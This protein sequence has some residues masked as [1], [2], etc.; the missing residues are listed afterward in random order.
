MKFSYVEVAGFRGFRDVTRFSFPAGFVVLTGR[1]GAGKS[2]VLD[3]IDYAFTGSINKY[4]IKGAKG[5]GLDSHIWWVGDGAPRAQYVEV[6]LVA[7]N[8][9]TFKIMRSRDRGLQTSMEEIGT[10][11]CSDRMAQCSWQETF[12]QT[13][14]IRDETLSGLS[15]DLP[16]QARFEAVRA[17]IGGLTG[18]DHSARTTELSK[19]A[20]AAKKAQDARLAEVQADLG[21]A[22]S[23]LT[24]ARSIAERQPDVSEAEEIIHRMAPDLTFI[25]GDRPEALR[26]RV[27]ERKQSIPDLMDAIVR[28]EAALADELFFTS[29]EGLACALDLAAQAEA[30][31]Q[32]KRSALAALGE[33][34]RAAA[35]EQEAD[36]F[37]AHMV[38]LLQ[39]GEGVGL[40]EGH[41]PLCNAV[42]SDGDFYNALEAARA[43]LQARG[44]AAA[45]AADSLTK[46]RSLALQAEQELAAAKRT[47][48]EFDSRRSRSAQALAAARAVFARHSVPADPLNP[49]RSR[50]LA[51]KRQEETAQLEHALFILEASGAHDRV[52]ALETRVAQLRGDVEEESLRATAAGRAVE[53]AKQID[54]AAKAVGNQILT[55][56]FDTVMPLL[57]ELYQRLRPHT[58][59]REIETDFG[60]EVRAS[61]NFTVGNGRNPQF[62]FSSGQ[63]RAAGLAF[64]LAIHLSRPWCRLRSLLLD[65]PVQHIDDYRALNLVEVLSAIR[66]MGRQVIIA[67]E[68]PA[69]ADLLCRRLRST[70]E[71]TGRRFDLS[72]GPSGSAIIDSCVDVRPLPREVLRFAE[73]S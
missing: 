45:R 62:L 3:A 34:E 16:E 64:L 9:Q 44:E 8:G 22:L 47:L 71:E 66:R 7:P 11:L 32:R 36:A 29:D 24:E 68:D 21:R 51:L 46:S 30:L 48:E 14:L 67:V 17:A 31:E 28:T 23:A 15:L 50:A 25:S 59:W 58:D 70:P 69:L 1:N 49:E 27:A 53:G 13:T 60:G 26:R 37:A 41:C 18:P 19:A 54:N 52:T 61:L 56:Q 43:R 55:E 63:R 39:H 57:K 65:D 10:H 40:I 12:I 73:A 20:A 72:F 33:A 35:A 4:A 6:G 42:R 5:G 38:A 2:T